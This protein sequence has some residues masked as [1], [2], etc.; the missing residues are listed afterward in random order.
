MEQLQD[1][2][3]AMAQ[4]QMERNADIYQRQRDMKDHLAGLE[5]LIAIRAFSVE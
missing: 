5:D 2:A 1:L 4:V 3:T